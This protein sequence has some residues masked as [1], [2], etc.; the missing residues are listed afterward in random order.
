MIHQ[1]IPNILFPIF[2]YFPVFTHY[3]TI[4]VKISYC[5]W[6]P[7]VVRNR[8]LSKKRQSRRRST[9]RFPFTLLFIIPRIVLLSS[10]QAKAETLALPRNLLKI[11]H[12]M[13]TNKGSIVK[14]SGNDV[15][16]CRS[17]KV[18]VQPNMR[19]FLQYSINGIE[20]G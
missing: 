11:S 3:E 1:Q 13:N 10:I 17:E 16:G 6:I 14:Q 15:E 18:L 19:V 5:K 20:T 9:G 4:S 7:F 12:H 2:P 8:T